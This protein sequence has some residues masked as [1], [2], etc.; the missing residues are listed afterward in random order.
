MQNQ[1]TRRDFFQTVSGGIMGG[2][3]LSLFEGRTQAAPLQPHLEPKATSVIHLFMNGGPSQMDLFDP[4]SKLDRLHGKSYFNKI[5]GEVENPTAAGSLMRCPYKFS[6]HGQCGMPVS[7]VMPHLSKCVDDIAFIR[8][9]HTTNITHEPA[10]FIAHSGRMQPGLPTLGSWISYGLGS[11]NQ[12]LPAYVVLEDPGKL[13][14]N[15]TQNW[16]AGFLPP[17]HQGTRFRAKGAPVLNLKPAFDQPAAIESLERDLI[18]RFNKRHKTA[19]PLQPRLDARIASYELAAR[20]QVEASDA[21]NLNQETETTKKM[22]GIG[23]KATDSYACRCLIAR[24]LV[25]RG[26]RFV[27]LFIDFQI[28]DNHTEIKKGLRGCCDKTD[29]PVAALLKDLKQRGLLDQTLVVWGGEFGRLPISQLPGDKNAGKAGRD[30]NK[31]AMVTWMAGGGTKG[32]VVHGAT[33][34]IGLA[35]V[36]DRVSIADWHATILHCLGLDHHKLVY[37]RNGLDERL[38]SVFDARVIKE[39]M[40]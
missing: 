11:E 39:I 26:V 4:K 30:H 10:L 19:R 2:A 9:M 25:E 18:A 8:S 16:Q 32:G 15:G 12:N 23:G 6:Q 17:Q 38:T 14:V 29:Q 1:A 36:E 40:K 21:L 5:A 33:D 31:N 34:D 27:Q 13:P 28:W 20:M 37:N 24:R 22:Y 3:L 35:A 7:E